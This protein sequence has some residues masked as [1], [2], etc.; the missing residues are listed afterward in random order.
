[1][2][3]KSVAIHEAQQHLA[4]LI[5]QVAAGVEIILLDGQVPCARL[6]P[7]TP[8]AV[9]RVPGLHAGSIT[10]SPDFDQSLPD[11]FWIGIA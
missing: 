4:E 5:A 11:E 1:M 7:I 3:T 8:H 6:V 9:Q 2:T 10:M